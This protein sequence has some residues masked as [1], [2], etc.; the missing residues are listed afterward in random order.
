MSKKGYYKKQVMGDIVIHDENRREFRISHTDFRNLGIELDENNCDEWLQALVIPLCHDLEEHRLGGYI[1]TV[2]V[3]HPKDPLECNRRRGSH[4]A[5]SHSP[6]V[7]LKDQPAGVDRSMCEEE[8][9]LKLPDGSQ[10][11]IRHEP[12][13]AVIEGMWQLLT[14]RLV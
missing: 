5:I 4:F 11:Y 2:Y 7:Y 14:L 3:S 10:L 8:Q 1:P 9:F 13:N 12:D 6:D